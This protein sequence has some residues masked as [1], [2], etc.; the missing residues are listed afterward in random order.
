[1]LREMVYYKEAQLGTKE[2]NLTDVQRKAKPVPIDEGYVTDKFTAHKSIL[3][4]V[5]A[6]MG[7]A[8][9]FS[10]DPAI[11]KFLNDFNALPEAKRRQWGVWK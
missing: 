2:S 5:A 1:M 11:E 9:D 3:K 7:V 4:K 6:N 8:I 10:D